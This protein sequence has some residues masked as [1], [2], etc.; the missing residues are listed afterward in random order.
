[1]WTNFVVV[2]API[3]HFCPGIVKAHEPVCV[4]AFRSKLA[5]KAFDER[6][7]RRFTRP[8]EVEDDILLIGPQIKVAG[9]E[10]A[11]LIDADR[12]R[13]ADAGQRRPLA[14]VIGLRLVL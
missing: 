14:C 9:D 12:T 13:I 10:L 7:V 3:L 2:S 5:V 6:I 8:R 4:Q 1:M 11:T